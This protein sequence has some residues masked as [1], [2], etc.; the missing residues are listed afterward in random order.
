MSEKIITVEGTISF[1]KFIDR[2]NRFLV[3]LKLEEN[4]KIESAFLHDPGRMKELLTPEVR[5]LIRKPLRIGTRK[6]KWDVL[7]VFHKNFWVT[8]NSSLPNL[9][10]KTALKNSW[11]EE[12][13][14]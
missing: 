2:P 10:A 7:A 8:I 9:V 1:A 12:L 14:E 13:A 11:I 4:G 5:L 3:N 6:T